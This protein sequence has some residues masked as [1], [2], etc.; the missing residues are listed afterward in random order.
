[1]TDDLTGQRHGFYK[2]EKYL[3]ADSYMHEV[4]WDWATGVDITFTSPHTLAKNPFT[5]ADIGN[6]VA[7]SDTCFSCD[8]LLEKPMYITRANTVIDTMHSTFYFVLC[9]DTDDGKDNPHW[10]IADIKEITE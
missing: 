5:T 2:M 9:D 3:I 10:A 8:I 6:F 4:A 7:Y 1:M